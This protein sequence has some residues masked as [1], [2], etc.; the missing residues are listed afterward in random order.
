MDAFRGQLFQR[1]RNRLRNKNTVPVIILSGMA[2][3]LQPLDES[4][5]KSFKHL[6]R[7]HYDVWLNK[8][9]HILTPSGKKKK[10]Q[11]QC[12]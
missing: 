3:L 7:K 12:Q 11:H 10:K 8:D 4:I 1:I 2:S 5:N 9:N 6:V